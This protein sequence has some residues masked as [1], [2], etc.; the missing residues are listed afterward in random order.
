MFDSKGRYGREVLLTRI[1]RATRQQVFDAWTDPKQLAVWWGPDQYS[2]P[3]CLLN[4]VPGG[5]MYI[6]MLA[7]DG[8]SY[9]VN[10]RY[11]DIVPPELLVFTSGLF[12]DRTGIDQ[13]EIEHTVILD[14]SLY[15]TRLTLHAVVMR[16]APGLR[17]KLDTLKDCWWQ[18]LS[19]LERLLEQQQL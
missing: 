9:P 15:G 12:E 14:K 13:L 10:G 4:L 2:N 8:T 3:V 19:R 18:S 11:R 1:I 6:V 17:Q 5:G 16:A 7:P